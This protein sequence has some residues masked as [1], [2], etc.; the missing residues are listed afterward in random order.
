MPKMQ[1]LIE[2]NGRVYPPRPIVGVGGIIIKEDKV[3]LGLRGKEP[4]KGKWSIPGGAVEI[5]ETLEEALAREVREE[6]GIKV[7]INRIVAILDRIIKDESDNTLYHYVLVDFLCIPE[8]NNSPRAGSDILECRYIPISELKCYPLTKGTN[9]VIEL[10][11]NQL[12][13]IHPL[14][15]IYESERSLFNMNG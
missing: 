10:S 14:S 8:G 3:L 2:H 4:E 9:R 13:G 7:R 11:F 1:T 15:T 5:G 12:R 6:V